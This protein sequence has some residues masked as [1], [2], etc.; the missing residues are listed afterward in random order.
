MP[1]GARRRRPS[2]AS[3]PPRRSPRPRPRS[4]A[5]RDL[6]KFRR[7]DA[8]ETSRERWQPDIRDHRRYSVFVSLGQ[9]HR[10]LREV[11]ADEIHGMI[12]RGELEPGERL[13]EDRLALQLGVSRNPV[14]EAIRALEG[15]G[16][17]EVL[18]R[19]GAYVSKI[20]PDQIVQLL[21]LRCV[22]EAY[23]AERA[24][25]RRTDADLIALQRCIDVGRAAAASSDLVTAAQCHREFHMI[26]ERASGNT[27]LDTVVAPLR[28]Q[29]ELVFTMLTDTRGSVELGRASGDPRRAEVRRRRQGAHGDRPAHGQRD[30]RHGAADSTR[31]SHTAQSEPPSDAS[32]APSTTSTSSSSEPASP[33]PPRRGHSPSTCASSSSNVS[34]PRRARD[35]TVGI[36]AVGD[37]G[38]PRRLHARPREPAVPRT[39]TGRV[40]RDTVARTAR[41][42]LGRPARRRGAPR[43][44]RRVGA[45][46]DTDRPPALTGRRRSNCC[47]GSVRSAVAGGAVHEPDAMS[48][49]T[50]ALLQGFVAGTRR[51]GS[52][53]PDDERGDQRG[54]QRAARGGSPRSASAS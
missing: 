9:S 20:E 36:G 42:G 51:R 12:M 32:P 5:H 53:G 11:V 50:A 29:T 39:P 52:I 23:A 44:V 3:P 34:R 26:V 15:T 8:A 43:L 24:A 54:R 38:A 30:P 13:Y 37:L 47:P 4:V 21:E 16:L 2:D 27:Y 6:V 46:V 22:I 35:R 49:D 19:R 7:P 17:V 1:S 33:A 40:L 48:I 10:T 45:P 31:C 28:H 41:A 18:P 25:I 14:R